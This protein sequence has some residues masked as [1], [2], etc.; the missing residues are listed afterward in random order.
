MQGG[1]LWLPSSVPTNANWGGERRAPSAPTGQLRPLP[2]VCA[3][4]SAWGISV[5]PPRGS[6][7]CAHP[8]RSPQPEAPKQRCS[9]V[10]ASGGENGPG[11][12]SWKQRAKSAPVLCPQPQMPPP[13]AAAGPGPGSRRSA[14][15]S[16]AVPKPQT[17]GATS[18][19][20][21]R[22]QERRWCVSG[23]HPFQ[24]LATQRLWLLSTEA[25][26]GG[27]RGRN[28]AVRR[29]L[30]Y[31]SAQP[32]AARCVPRAAGAGGREPP[33]AS[34]PPAADP[35]LPPLRDLPA[36]PSSPPPLR[37]FLKQV[38]PLPLGEP[39]GACWPQPRLLLSPETV[40]HNFEASGCRCGPG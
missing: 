21:S 14:P 29:H 22:A 8:S 15:H 28:S 34:P 6:R 12:L 26:G 19:R 3:P 30:L 2:E 40:F 5:Y 17:P 10:P 25:R 35:R 4:V 9:Q 13:T 24:R 38:H 36:S 27:G 18:P 33:C 23:D 37:P 20:A 32:L 39:Q 31:T 7:C 11:G 16:P 1:R